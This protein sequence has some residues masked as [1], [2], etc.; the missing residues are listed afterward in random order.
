MKANTG[1][2]LGVFLWA[3]AAQA[4][5]EKVRIAPLP[6]KVVTG[7]MKL[8]TELPR[9]FEMRLLG[10]KLVECPLPDRVV[11][12]LRSR[13]GAPCEKDAACLKTLA[14]NTSSLYA[15]ASAVMMNGAGDAFEVNATIFRIDGVRKDVA[16]EYKF[17]R[18]VMTL[19]LAGDEMLK[20]LISRLELDRLER[21]LPL[22]SAPP[23]PVPPEAL[24]VPVETRIPPAR[25]AAYVAGGLAAGAGVTAL[26]VGMVASGEASRVSLS[27]EG[28]LLNPSQLA[29]AKA[30]VEKS[31]AATILGA[32]AGVGVAAAVIILLVTP[33]REPVVTV[34]PVVGPDVV[35]ASM[36]WRL[37]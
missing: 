28:E 30:S 25:I 7:D 11:E 22:I 8:D 14:E 19:N 29:L 23:P 4:Q 21:V 3:V 13:S 24:P 15:L 1:V 32:T 36:S 35:G 12:F 18:N 9:K 5:T 37:P 17:N 2:A 6:M 33:A 27:Q 26:A 20:E 10:S 31:T 16:F 34:A